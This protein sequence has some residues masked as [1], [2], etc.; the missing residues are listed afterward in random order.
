MKSLQRS[1]CFSRSV[2]PDFLLR[3][4]V[5]AVTVDIGME[6]DLLRDFSGMVLSFRAH[7]STS[8]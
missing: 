7:F 3:L 4:A 5:D 1:C 6:G 8:I 2:L